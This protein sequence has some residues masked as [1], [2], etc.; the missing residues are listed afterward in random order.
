M[1]PH[2]LKDDVLNAW[3]WK[4]VEEIELN[5]RLFVH[6]SDDFRWPL[7]R[8]WFGTPQQQEFIKDCG[9][10]C[11][12]ADRDNN[13][14]FEF[15]Y[16]VVVHWFRLWPVVHWRGDALDLYRYL[17]SICADIIHDIRWR[18]SL[19]AD[20]KTHYIPWSNFLTTDPETRRDGLRL[21]HFRLEF[22]RLLTK[23]RPRPLDLGSDNVKWTTNRRRAGSFSGASYRD[24]QRTTFSMYPSASA[25]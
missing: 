13:C 5:R 14:I 2:I 23:Q 4:I 17:F 10:L 24:R 7:R 9:V 11:I 25:F 22:Q 8:T 20:V 6:E 19:A 3:F 12:S 1:L 16:E 18:Y 21:V 15:F